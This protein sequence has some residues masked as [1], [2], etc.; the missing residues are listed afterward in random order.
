MQVALN[1]DLTRV[2]SGPVVG[3]L[4]VHTAGGN[5]FCEAVAAPCESILELA[6]EHLHQNREQ[7]FMSYIKSLNTA[8]NR[9]ALINQACHGLLAPSTGVCSDALTRIVTLKWPEK[10][11]LSWFSNLCHPQYEGRDYSN[12]DGMA[13][14][15]RC[16]PGLRSYNLYGCNDFTDTGLQALVL[17]CVGLREL[18]FSNA[19]HVADSSLKILSQCPALT[20][21]DLNNCKLVTDFGI[22][23]LCANCPQLRSL[24]LSNCRHWE[25]PTVTGACIQSIAAGCPGLTNLN[26]RDSLGWGNGPIDTEGLIGK[27]CQ[28][29]VKLSINNPDLADESIESIGKHCKHL[30][31]LDLSDCVLATDA[32]A[33]AIGQGCP[34]LTMLKY[35]AKTDKAV[36]AIAAGCPLLTQLWFDYGDQQFVTDDGLDKLAAGCQKLKFCAFSWSAGITEEGCA[37]FQASVLPLTDFMHRNFNPPSSSSS[38]SNSD[39]Y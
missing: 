9:Y 6:V 10:N 29:L 3:A 14:V 35:A 27:H 7:L 23:D 37:R 1:D 21:L 33:I 34:L 39:D 25:S 32:S 13:R 8:L 36:E 2:A 17:G 5:T 16:C 19:E 18:D 30:T 15:A 38:D 24:C 26:L 31:E 20:A 11:P 22:K 28:S 4:Q 12:D